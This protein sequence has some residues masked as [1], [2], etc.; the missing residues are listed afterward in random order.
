MQ[1]QKKGIA[2]LGSTGS[3]GTQALEVI[4]K[5]DDLFELL[6][7]TANKNADLLIRQAKKHQPNTVVIVDENQYQ[8]VRDALW[9]DGI[10][11]YAGKSALEQVVEMTEIHLVLNALI[12]YA[13]L[14]PTIN[15]IRHKK[16][17]ALANKETL[18]VAGELVTQ[19]A[20]ENEVAI[21]PIDSEHSAIFQCLAGEIYNPIEKIY[22]TASGGPFRGFSFEKLKKATKK[23]ALSHPKWKMGNKIT[24]DSATMMNK[25]FEVIEAKWLFGLK[26]NQIDILVH[27]ES[28]IHSMV[29]FEDGSIKAQL[30]MPDMKTPIQYAIFY[31]NRLNLDVKRMNFLQFNQLNFESFDRKTFKNVDLA[32]HAMQEGGTMA[33]A[34]NAANEVAVALF[35]EDKISFLQIAEINEK[36][37]MTIPNRQKAQLSDFIEVDALSREFAEHLTQSKL[38]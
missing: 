30:G 3:I 28:I 12:G 13:G 9:E 21:L 14:L 2:I 5:H 17:I 15:A 34:L 18:V 24:I 1:E 6:V 10:K 29:Q 26:A 35:L 16:N 38:R 8:T 25:G 33:C 19:L 27:P 22:L 20:K 36:T 23:E 37:I 7:I 4:S 32:Y 31:P 11:V